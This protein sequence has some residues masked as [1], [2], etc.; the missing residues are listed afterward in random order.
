MTLYDVITKQIEFNVILN[1][2]LCSDVFFE[3]PQVEELPVCMSNI[4]Y[5]PGNYQVTGILIPT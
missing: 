5:L 2:S 4:S 1:D 3:I